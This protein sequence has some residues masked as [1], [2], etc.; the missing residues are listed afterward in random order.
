[1]ISRRQLNQ[2]GA[3]AVAGMAVAQAI[4]S[5]AGAQASN[6]PASAIGSRPMRAARMTGFRR[7]LQ[8]DE[9]PVAAPR[10]D[11]GGARGGKRRVPQ[12]LALLE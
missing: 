7:P 1:M 4:T 11:G 6:G 10:A 12:R 9:V 2:R 3:S 5:E 8:V